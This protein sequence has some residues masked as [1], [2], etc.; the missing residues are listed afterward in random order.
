MKTTLVYQVD[1][2]CHN[3]YLM[4]RFEARTTNR[5]M[6][7]AISQKKGSAKSAK[8]FSKLPNKLDT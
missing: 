5:G 2:V 8:A 7:E 4:K 6:I 1:L 3:E